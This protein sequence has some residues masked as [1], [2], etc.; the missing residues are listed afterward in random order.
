MTPLEIVQH[1]RAQI[2]LPFA[3]SL[4]KINKSVGYIAFGLP[5][6]LLAVSALTDTCTANGGLDSLSHYYYTQIGGD[7]FVA[8]L[9]L[10][11]VLLL[12][13]Y[14]KPAAVDGYLNHKPLDM[15]LAKLAGAAA[16]VIAFVPTSGAGCPTGSATLRPY[17]IDIPDLGR[18]SGGTYPLPQ[19]TLA[20]DFWAA[21]G[22]DSASLGQV[23]NLGALV[24]FLILGYFSFSVFARVNSPEALT[25]TLAPTRKKRVRN[26]LYRSLGVV[27][28]LSVA[29]LAAKNLVFPDAWRARW[30][31]ANLTFW[32]EA[33]GLWA[34]GASWLI[35]G[36]FWKG[37]ED[38]T[39]L[40]RHSGRAA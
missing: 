35:K 32:T 10:I 27:I 34:F 6:A 24:M 16:L 2:D 31:A 9:S 26:G 13:F 14:T 33:V 17:L 40:T 11:G 5:F 8:A 7:L 38:E 22:I 19:S 30:D 3:V 15:A 29:T 20:F 1:P 21:M 25:E 39:G 23:H 4:K 28:F 18:I 12:V 36:R 37:L